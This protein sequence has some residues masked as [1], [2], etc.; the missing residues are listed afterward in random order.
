MD[1]LINV[2]KFSIR[3]ENTRANQCSDLFHVTHAHNFEIG[4]RTCAVETR[5]PCCFWKISTVLGC[6]LN[7]DNNYIVLLE[8]N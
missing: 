8:L 1:V 3:D 2:S 4:H 6:G 5:W 7:V